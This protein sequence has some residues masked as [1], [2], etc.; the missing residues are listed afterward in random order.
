MQVLEK[1]LTKT[2]VEIISPSDNWFRVSAVTG[3]NR[4]TAEYGETL[5]IAIAR[6][7]KQLFDGQAEHR[8]IGDTSYPVGPRG[9]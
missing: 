6:F 7:A 4:I 8:Q 9:L 5:P 3:F 1:C 2:P